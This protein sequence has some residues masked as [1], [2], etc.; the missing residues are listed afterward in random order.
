VNLSYHLAPRFD[1]IIGPGDLE[2]L[3]PSCQLSA[4]H[5]PARTPSPTS[6]ICIGFLEAIISPFKFSGI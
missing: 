6:P 1:R 4:M 3:L 2:R 5:T